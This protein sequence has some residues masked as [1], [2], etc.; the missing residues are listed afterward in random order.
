MAFNFQLKVNSGVFQHPCA[1]N[2]QIRLLI[3][4]TD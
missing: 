4:L 2:P 1:V 3:D